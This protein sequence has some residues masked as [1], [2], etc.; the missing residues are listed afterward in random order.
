MRRQETSKSPSTAVT[1]TPAYVH[2]EVPYMFC[3]T[4]QRL[5]TETTMKQIIRK[6]EKYQNCRSNEVSR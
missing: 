5:E 3:R 6:R 1:P 4:G 2:D